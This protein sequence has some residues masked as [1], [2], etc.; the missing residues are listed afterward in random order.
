MLCP[1]C[2]DVELIAV[3]HFRQRC[4]YGCE[5]CGREFTKQGNNLT[6]DAR[7]IAEQIAYEIAL[8]QPRLEE[9]IDSRRVFRMT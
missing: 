2:G 8:S 1:C 4:R 3:N 7:S 9:L 6:D 5:E